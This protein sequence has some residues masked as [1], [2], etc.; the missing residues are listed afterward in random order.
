MGWAKYDAHVHL[1]IQFAGDQTFLHSASHISQMTSMEHQI[2]E[3]THLPI[4][5]NAPGVINTKVTQAMH[6]AMDCIYLAQLPTHTER[7]LQAYKTAY[8]DFMANWQGWIENKTR[9][10]KCKV[11]PHLHIPKMHVIHHFAQHIC[12]KGSTD[13]FTTETMEHLHIGVKEAYWASNRWEWKQQ[14]V[15]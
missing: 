1:Q 2:L 14:T 5:A 6:R 15:Q 4:I 13:N 10:G 11:I 8:Q 12:Q 7:S 3:Q 9:K